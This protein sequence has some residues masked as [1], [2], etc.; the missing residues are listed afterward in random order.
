MF[1]LAGPTKAV[2]FFTVSKVTVKVDYVAYKGSR[3]RLP[4]GKLGH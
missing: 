1:K 4:V 2:I 3:K